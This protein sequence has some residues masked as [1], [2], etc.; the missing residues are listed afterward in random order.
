MPSTISRRRF[1]D[2]F[3]VQAD[4]SIKDAPALLNFDDG[5]LYSAIE[6]DQML[7]GDMDDVPSTVPFPWNTMNDMDADVKPVFPYSGLSNYEYAPP[8]G[9]SYR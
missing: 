6:H 7:F 2:D 3:G 5:N 4:P 8:P 1:S 9:L